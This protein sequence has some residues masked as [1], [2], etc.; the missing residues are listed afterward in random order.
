[1]IEL[2]IPFIRQYW[3]QLTIFAWFLFALVFSYYKGYS[4]EHQKFEAHLADDKARIEILKAEYERKLAAQ[5]EV[6]R[7]VTKEYAHAINELKH[8]Y[9]S[10]PNIKWMSTS[11]STTNNTTVS[12]SASSI[13]AGT[14][15]DQVSAAGVTPL[16]CASDVLQLLYLQKW[17]KDQES[18]K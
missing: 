5:D 4:H 2:V 14:Q 11:L 16:D 15:S 12:E 18:I 9:E 17:V 8:Y 7:N 10:H 13:N 6:T 3:K 1:M